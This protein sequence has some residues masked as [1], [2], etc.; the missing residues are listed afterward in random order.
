MATTL[1]YDK[2]SFL[3]FNPNLSVQTPNAGK[4]KKKMHRTIVLKHLFSDYRVTINFYTILDTISNTF[5]KKFGP[6][7]KT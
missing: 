2:K 1:I 6:F 5:S 4:K 3:V 7:L